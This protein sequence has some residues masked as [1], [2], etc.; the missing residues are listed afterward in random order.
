MLIAETSHVGSGRAEWIRELTDEVVLAVE[1]GVPLQGICL[2]PII[3]RFEW[4]NPSHWHNSGLWDFHHEPDGTLRRVL[5]QPYAA[6]LARSQSRLA[7]L[8]C[9]LAEPEEATA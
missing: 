9:G 6:E 3:D 7:T 1:A 2:Y 5:A 4:D 8:G